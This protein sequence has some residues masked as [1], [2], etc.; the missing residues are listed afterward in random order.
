MSARN[1]EVETE[2][3]DGRYTFRLGLGE[4]E[5][6]QEKCDAGPGFILGRLMSP[7]MEWKLEDVRH[8]IRLGL[9]GGGM[10]ST[11]AFKLVER[12]IDERPAWAENAKLAQAILA[13]AIFGLAE[14]E[15]EDPDK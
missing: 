10:K 8:T 6:L 14:E 1:A 12:Y 2:F 9:I 3:G 11:E 13:L 7:R 15:A 5:E 4:L